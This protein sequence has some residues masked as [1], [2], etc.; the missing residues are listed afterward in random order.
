MRLIDA[1][2]RLQAAG[3][4]AFRTGDAAAL[5]DIPTANAAKILERL[6]S[7][8]QI[9]KLKHSVWAFPEK[10]DRLALATWLS[11]PAPSYVSLHSALYFHGMIEQ[12][13]ATLYAVTVG[14]T[15]RYRTPL[16]EVSLHRVHPDFF[17]GYAQTEADGAFLAEPEKALIDYLYLS[18]A[19]SRLFGPL[20][21]LEFPKSFRFPKARRYIRRVP[22]RRTR[23]LVSREFERLAVAGR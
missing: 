9:V 17:F 16:G 23:S 12:V 19:R 13:P 22:S 5:L 14:R 21:E 10:V 8:G 1:L 3:V 4:P 7:A 15:R 20:P 11:A 6:R 18:P 2:K